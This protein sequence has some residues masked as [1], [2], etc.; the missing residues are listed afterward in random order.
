MIIYGW[1]PVREAIRS[2]PS[3][4]RFV[5]VAQ[6]EEHG[7]RARLVA[8]LK[9]AG[10]PVRYLPKAR[11]DRLAEGGV[12][13]GVVAEVASVGYA[14]FE[15]KVREEGLR[16]VLL[17][18]QIQDPQNVGA[19]LRVADA[20]GV[21]LVAMTEHDSAGLTPV[22][23]KASAGAAEWVPVAQVTNLSRAIESLKE[24]GFWVYG[25]DGS[26]DELSGIDLRGKVALVLGSEG[27][28]I[29][30]NVRAHCDRLVRIPMRGKVESLNVATA[31][32]VLAY[33]V[34]RQNREES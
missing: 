8:E 22:V 4:I 9:D 7:K 15:E 31:A 2:D 21:D 10:V 19:I 16:F 33:E 14:D 1:N 11:L 28:G 32:A 5:A 3:R 26:G 27:G 34:D 23:V 13:N 30:K 29:R 24:S 18:D 17:L 20:M 12:H 25:A 6:G